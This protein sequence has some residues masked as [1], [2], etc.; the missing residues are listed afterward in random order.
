MSL[1]FPWNESAV[2]NSPNNG[3]GSLKQKTKDVALFTPLKIREVTLKN[4]IA[5][6]PMYVTTKYTKSF[7][8]VSVGVNIL[9]KMGS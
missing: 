8:Y 4:R 1:T 3:P 5:V 6:S 7:S 2:T 9:V